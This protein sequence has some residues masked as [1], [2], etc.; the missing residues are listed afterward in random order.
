[1]TSRGRHSL[2]VFFGLA[3]GAWLALVLLPSKQ[4]PGGGSPGAAETIFTAAPSRPPAEPP[5][6]VVLE[7]W[8][9]ARATTYEH[10]TPRYVARVSLRN[11][12]PLPAMG[13][14]QVKPV[15]A[16]GFAIDSGLARIVRLQGT[17]TW[18][19]EIEF[20]VAPE[21]DERSVRWQFEWLPISR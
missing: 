15:D 8:S 2:Q 14:L 1:M 3:A 5:S 20:G 10:A 12:G 7:S 21:I 9:I 17:E 16:E 19:S 4:S 18:R 6:P 13:L 11:P